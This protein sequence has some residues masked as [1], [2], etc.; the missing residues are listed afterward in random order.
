MHGC[1]FE[2]ALHLRR[3]L[4]T[5]GVP[6]GSEHR[7]H[8]HAAIGPAD[9]LSKSD[10][11]NAQCQTLLWTERVCTGRSVN[12]HSQLIST[13]VVETRCAEVYI[14]SVT[15][16]CFRSCQI[17]RRRLTWPASASTPASRGWQAL[18]ALGEGH[19]EVHR[20]PWFGVV[21][22]SKTAGNELVQ[23]LCA[24]FTTRSA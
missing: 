23:K 6:F 20:S 22:T 2:E 5:S 17:S 3:A 4:E 11:S 12:D 18:L 16:R 19:V 7:Q 24:L 10:W 1:C 15:H 14:V 9:L 21:I 13:A 8:R